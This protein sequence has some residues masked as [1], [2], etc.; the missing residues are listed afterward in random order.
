MQHHSSMHYTMYPPP[1][2]IIFI[3]YLNSIDFSILIVDPR[4]LH[5]L[6]VLTIPLVSPFF[7]FY[8]SLNGSSK[9]F[10][11]KNLLYRVLNII[12]VSWIMTLD[13]II[14]STRRYATDTILECAGKTNY[15]VLFER[16]WLMN[17]ILLIP[18]SH[19]KE[20]TSHPR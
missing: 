14:G 7:Y 19:I 3:K 18:S 20:L 11:R 6:F 8:L 5:P 10:H 16:D 4:R 15:A 1:D 9:H 13:Q 2:F 12:V 17:Y